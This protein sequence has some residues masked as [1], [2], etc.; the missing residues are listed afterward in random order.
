MLETGSLTKYRVLS[1]SMLKLIAV[2][3]MFIDHSA[4][5][6]Y[7]ELDCLQSTLFLLGEKEITLYFI[8]RKIGRLA[9]PIFCF[10][11]TEG[12]AHTK[13]P[14]RYCLRLLVFAVL[15]EIPFNLMLGNRMFYS[16]RQNVYFTLLFGVLLIYCFE[17]IKNEVLQVFCMGL[18]AAGAAV[19]DADYGLR[20]ALL[21]LLLYVL[22]AL[23]AAQ[24]ILA[25]PLLSGGV[26][27]FAAFIPI[28]MYNGQR[29]FI[30]S[31]RMKLIFYWFYP[32][33]ILFLLM[34][35]YIL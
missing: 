29:G 26:A 33:H 27:A 12:F 9:F 23:P 31:T 34:I 7:R 10:L 32:V 28:H 8:L 20:G 22:R 15:S 18:I 13:N 35:K 24:T 4:G 14:K 1:G 2:I 6:L 3:T 25:Y 5:I 11:I 17:A 19:L 16:A 30:Q 21:P